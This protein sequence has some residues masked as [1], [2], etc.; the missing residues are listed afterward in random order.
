MKRRYP[1]FALVSL[2]ILG[3]VACSKPSAQDN[4]SEDQLNHFSGITAHDHPIADNIQERASN[5]NTVA[6]QPQH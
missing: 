3:L 1:A 6:N 4:L 5:A 2:A